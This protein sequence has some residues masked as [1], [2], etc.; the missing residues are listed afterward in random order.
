MCSC[1]FVCLCVCPHKQEPL[2][3]TLPTFK[4]IIPCLMT[5]DRLP[6]C[7]GGCTHFVAVCACIVAGGGFILAVCKCIVAVCRC[8]VGHGVGALSSSRC[9][10]AA[11][12]HPL[13]RLLCCLRLQEIV[14][15]DV[16]WYDAPVVVQKDLPF[17]IVGLLAFEFFAM[18]WVEVRRWQDFR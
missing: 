11:T 18:H 2:V 4:D 13:S 5:S 9:M 3:V 10:L 6:A 7:L 1:V 15:P 14:R 8:T 12:D 16:F 17:G